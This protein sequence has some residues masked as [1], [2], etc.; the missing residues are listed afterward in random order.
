MS[1]HR[2]HRSLLP[3]SVK[4]KPLIVAGALAVAIAAGSLGTLPAAASDRV[5][6]V[7]PGQTLSQIAAA[8]GTTVER[9]VAL[10]DLA[11]PNRIYVGQRIRV[12]SA[13]K[14]AAKPARHAQAVF[15]RVAYGETLTGIAARYGKTISALVV[16]NGLADASRIYAGQVLRISGAHRQARRA[17]GGSVPS[18]GSSRS[19]HRGRAIVHIVRAGETLSGIAVRYRVSTIA[20]A[21]ANRLANP[22]FIR[23]GQQLRIPGAHRARETRGEHRD[24]RPAVGMPPSMAELVG[25]RRAMRHLIAT[26]ARRQSVP[27]ALALAVAW[28]ESGW[29]SRVVSSAGA[30]GVMQLLPAT[31][32]WVSATMLGEPVNLWN[33]RSNTRAGVALLKHYLARYGN[34]PLALAAY[35]Q[36]QAGTDR[37]GI[38]PVSRAYVASILLLERMFGR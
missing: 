25:Q 37:Y 33:A 23:T 1:I 36:G 29:Q 8:H 21:A 9:L 2:S 22:S 7:Q 34:R 3:R 15:H 31:A 20:I 35:Y 14:P 16:R 32:D 10:N 26:E 13:Q 11:D 24:S 28:Q 38:Y 12:R 18:G 5:V 19:A 6:V 27:P 17:H 30:I 4:P